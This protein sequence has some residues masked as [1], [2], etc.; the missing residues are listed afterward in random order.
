MS[1]KE[2]IMKDKRLSCGED[3]MDGIK[4]GELSIKTNHQRFQPRDT[5]PSSDSTS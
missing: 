1:I 4:D 2:R 5:V 3:I